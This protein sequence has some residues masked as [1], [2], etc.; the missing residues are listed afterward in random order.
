MQIQQA[1][2]WYRWL[3]LSPIFTIPTLVYVYFISY[4]I[5]TAVLISASWHLILLIPAFNSS[6]EFVRWHGKQMLALAALRT[7]IPL[8]FA[9]F[10]RYEDD[11]IL[12]GHRI[13]VKLSTLWKKGH[14]V[15]QQI[16][17]QNYDFIV[18]LGISPHN[19]HCWVIDK[20]TLLKYVIGHRP[21]HGGKEGKDTFWLHVKPQEVES[22][23]LK[24]GG[25]LDQ[26]LKKLVSLNKKKS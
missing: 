24:S 19:G 12:N 3:W 1:R 9:F 5:P 22:W 7:L 13:E 26:G 6:S 2:K 8:S 18:C 23:M 15:F 21:Q 14:Y 17:D 16:R 20:K 11:I 10:S 4:S 25:T